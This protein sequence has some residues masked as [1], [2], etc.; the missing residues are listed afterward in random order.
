MIWCVGHPNTTRP[1]LLH[2]PRVD[3][4]QPRPRLPREVASQRHQ[5]SKRANYTPS[6]LTAEPTLQSDMCCNE[7]TADFAQERPRQ[8]QECLTQMLFWIAQLCTGGT[9]GKISKSSR[10]IERACSCAI[11]GRRQ[12]RRLFTASD[13]GSPA[14]TRR[15]GAV[16]ARWTRLGPTWLAWGARLLW[17]AVLVCS[18]VGTAPLLRDHHRGRSAWHAYHRRR[19]WSGPAAA[20][21][22]LVLV[23]GGSL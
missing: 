18:A 6:Q 22:K 5:L 21:S 19:S 13:L 11:I 16:L 20:R 7:L 15:D 1:R 4:R 10:R 9:H 14:Q 8:P 12:C 2:L 3:N 23:L 17:P